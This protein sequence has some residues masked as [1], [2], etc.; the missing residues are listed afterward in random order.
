[1]APNSCRELTD[2]AADTLGAARDDYARTVVAIASKSGESIKEIVLNQLADLRAGFALE[3]ANQK[4][5][6]VAARRGADVAALT[7]EINQIDATACP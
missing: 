7:A 6:S 3:V 5:P 1:V 2:L 4:R